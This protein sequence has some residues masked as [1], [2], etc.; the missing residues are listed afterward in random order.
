MAHN[1]A[2]AGAKYTRSRRPVTLA[3]VEKLSDV[4]TALKRENEIK[5]LTRK[6]KL[7]LVLSRG[8][9]GFLNEHTIKVIT[10]GN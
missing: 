10:Q 1:G 2:R 8:E 7:E 3:Y 5:Q 6:E 4:G 9:V